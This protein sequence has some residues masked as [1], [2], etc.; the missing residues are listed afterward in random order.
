MAAFVTFEDVSKVY[1]SGEV[2][3]RAVESMQLN[4][5]PASVES[6]EW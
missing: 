1:R 6:I 5:N 4:E 2:E 3:I